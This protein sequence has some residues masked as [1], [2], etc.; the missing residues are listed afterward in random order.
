MAGWITDQPDGFTPSVW[1]TEANAYDDDTG[2]GAGLLNDNTTWLELTCSETVTDCDWLRFFGKIQIIAPAGFENGSWTIEVDWGTGYVGVHNGVLIK[3][4]WNYINIGAVAP[5]G[6][7][8]VEKIRIKSNIKTTNKITLVQEVGVGR[9]PKENA[10]VGVP[11]GTTPTD[12]AVKIS[13]GSEMW[14]PPFFYAD[15][16]YLYHDTFSPPTT[17]RDSQNTAAAV[18]WYA[19]N[20]HDWQLV[21]QYYWRVDADNDVTD[22]T[23][24]DETTGTELDFTISANISLLKGL[25]G[26]QTG[27][28]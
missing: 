17:L 5:A 15:T 7:K 14:T 16:Q 26:V 13:R 12:G 4:A 8:D 3:D 25:L 1:S 10:N 24:A 28:R 23:I 9:T 19:K 21:T 22:D 2:S 27:R 11:G 20:A 18:E 6:R